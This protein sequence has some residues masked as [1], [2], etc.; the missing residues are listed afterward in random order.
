MHTT[1]LLGLLPNVTNVT[2][3]APIK[4][5]AG[6]WFLLIGGALLLILAFV[7]FYLLKQLVANAIAGIIALLV[8]VYIFGIPIPLTPFIILVCVLGGLGGVGAV[9]IA[10]F[11]GWI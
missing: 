9:L 1:I 6:N 8:L 3:Y 5:F 7:V 11:L 2:Q 4:A 10:T